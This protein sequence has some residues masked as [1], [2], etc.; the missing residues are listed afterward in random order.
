MWDDYLVDV[1]INSKWGGFNKKYKDIKFLSY[2]TLKP[3]NGEF[4]Q[5]AHLK[6]NGSKLKIGNKIKTGEILGLS[7]NTGFTSRP[8]LHFHV[9][10][11]N[12]TKIGWE[13]LKIR[14]KEKLKILKFRKK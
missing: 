13:T 12:K 7:G 5:Y 10:K 3:S 6:Y 8:H 1:K 2:I 14:F 11:L 9:L 4:S